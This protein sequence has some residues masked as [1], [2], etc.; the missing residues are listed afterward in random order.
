MFECTL[1]KFVG[2]IKLFGAADTP[3]RGDAIQR[4]LDRLDHWAKVNLMMFE[5][6][7]YNVLHMGCGNPH[8]QYKLG[9][10]RMDHSI[11]KMRCGY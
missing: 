3:Q 2:D 5:K 10:L 8:Y 6:D 7:K 4:D 1:S 11:T 9:N